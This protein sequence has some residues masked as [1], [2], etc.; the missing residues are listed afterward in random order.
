VPAPLSYLQP[1][2]KLEAHPTVEAAGF[3]TDKRRKI[4]EDI[5]NHKKEIE[6]LLGRKIEILS[7]ED[8]AKLQSQR[9]GLDEG[10]IGAKWVLAFAECLCQRRRD[11]APIDEPTG[12][13]VVE[14]GEHAK[15]WEGPATA[16]PSE[17]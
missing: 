16:S 8:W 1:G 11:R 12:L 6:D 13:W 5:A 2:E 9:A 14:L 4:T 3:V 10:E 15:S 7:L 17:P